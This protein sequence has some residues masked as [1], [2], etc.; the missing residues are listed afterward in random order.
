[1]AGRRLVDVLSSCL[2]AVSSTKK[3]QRQPL[4][5]V[6]L[7]LS[8]ARSAAVLALNKRVAGRLDLDQITAWQAELDKVYTA[9]ADDADSF[10]NCNNS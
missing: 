1:V 10:S 9:A 8:C 2:P 6:Q 3:R 7:T 5:G 4:D